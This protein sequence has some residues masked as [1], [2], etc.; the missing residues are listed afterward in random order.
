MTSAAA[1]AAAHPRDGA[2]R[3]DDV[4]AG[5]VK[6]ALADQAPGS[7]GSASARVDIDGAAAIAAARDFVPLAAQA[8]TCSWPGTRMRGS[9]SGWFRCLTRA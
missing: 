7:R 3:L 6:I 5:R 9:S 4:L 1:L 8:T 2:I